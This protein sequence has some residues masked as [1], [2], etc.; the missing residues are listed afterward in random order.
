MSDVD[1]YSYNRFGKKGVRV[2]QA[3]MDLLSS[4]PNKC[5][6][7]D[8]L[9]Q[10]GEEYIKGIQECAEEQ[11]EKF[12][13]VFHIVS[14]MKKDLTHFN[15]ENVVRHWTIPRKTCP[16]MSDM[17]YAY[18]NYA[19]TVFQVDSKKGEIT[20]LWTL[21]GYQDS[22]SIQKNKHLYDPQ[23]AEWA[24]MALGS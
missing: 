18:P 22:K 16:L 19:S 12:D 15:L 6:V 21:P 1:K 14:L 8:I 5:S 13:G 4:N 10:F 2:G 9:D 24:D 3:A 7:E 20:L 23:L 11:K 17:I